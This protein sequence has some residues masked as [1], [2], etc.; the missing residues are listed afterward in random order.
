MFSRLYIEPL[1]FDYLLNLLEHQCIRLRG[2]VIV[3]LFQRMKFVER[4]GSALRGI[5]SETESSPSYTEELRLEFH[6]SSTNFRAVLKNVNYNKVACDHVSDYDTEHDARLVAMLDF[7]RRP[8]SKKEPG[9]TVHRQQTTQVI[10][11]ILQKSVDKSRSCK[12]Y[13]T[14]V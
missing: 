6:S 10:P 8:K 9:I 3:D 7:C 13:L 11:G 5:V 4:H 1:S 12:Y 2:P 14:E